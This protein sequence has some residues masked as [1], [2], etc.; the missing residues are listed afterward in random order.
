MSKPLVEV[1]HI[2]FMFE[3]WM[4]EAIN[5]EPS[6]LCTMPLNWQASFPLVKIVIKLLSSFIARGY[7]GTPLSSV[8]LKTNLSVV[9]EV[10]NFDDV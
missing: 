10:L 8:G 5:E 3:L 1:K 2:K 4:T 9:F 6:Q 7:R